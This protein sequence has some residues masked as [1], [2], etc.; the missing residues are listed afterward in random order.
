MFELIGLPTEWLYSPSMCFMIDGNTIEQREHYHYYNDAEIMAED[1]EEFPMRGICGRGLSLNWNMA[2]LDRNIQDLEYPPIFCQDCLEILNRRKESTLAEIGYL[3]A[4]AENP[5]ET[6]LQALEDD[7]EFYQP[8][9]D[10][11]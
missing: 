10:Y 6:I 9:K 7:M 3:T 11:R 4:Y 2:S 5:N 1:E 8:T